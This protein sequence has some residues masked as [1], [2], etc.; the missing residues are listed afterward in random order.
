MHCSGHYLL[1]RARIISAA[2]KNPD[3]GRSVLVNRKVGM[4]RGRKVQAVI[5][6]VAYDAHDLPVL[7]R[8][9]KQAFANR[10]AVRVSPDKRFVDQ[11]NSFGLLRVMFL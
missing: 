2:E 4:W 6:H 8:P 9:G 11:R 3:F 5:M 1:Q 7:A 10:R